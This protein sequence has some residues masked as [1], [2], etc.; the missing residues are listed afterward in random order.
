MLKIV[1]FSR[2]DL[3][4]N[5]RVTHMTSPSKITALLTKIPKN[6]GRKPFLKFPDF[7]C[8]L[9]HTISTNLDLLNKI[10]TLY[11]WYL[12]T[13]T[14]DRYLLTCTYRYEKALRKSSVSTR[15]FFFLPTCLLKCPCT[16]WYLLLIFVKA[17]NTFV[18]M[19]LPQPEAF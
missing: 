18:Y 3:K 9:W 14:I 16:P 12:L 7:L 5:I 8:T 10:K 13:L 2:L 1:V 17:M 11:H 15:C 4:K 19:D 6:T